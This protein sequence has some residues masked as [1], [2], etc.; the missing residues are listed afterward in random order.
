MSGTVSTIGSAPRSIQ[1]DEYS[2]STL[3]RTTSLNDA[4][5]KLR[6]CT[7]WFTGAAKSVG[8]ATLAIFARVMSMITSG[9]P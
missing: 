8:L 6:T 7:N 1:A 9:R 2:V 3:A 5:G 4:S